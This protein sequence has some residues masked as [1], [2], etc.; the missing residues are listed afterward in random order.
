MNGSW[1]HVQL[2]NTGR[3]LCMLSPR[4]SCIGKP[5]LHS[6]LAI[7]ATFSPVPTQ[8]FPTHVPNPLFRLHFS[9]LIR[10]DLELGQYLEAP[11]PVIY[12]QASDSVSL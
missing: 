5:P 7:A 8:N 10:F 11:P 4:L 12:P 9:I 3:A 1:A 6:S 2:R